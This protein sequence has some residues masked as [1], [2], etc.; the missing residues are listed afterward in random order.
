M[1]SDKKAP[2]KTAKEKKVAKAQKKSNKN[3]ISKDPIV[4]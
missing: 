4:K 3:N 2:A 1:K